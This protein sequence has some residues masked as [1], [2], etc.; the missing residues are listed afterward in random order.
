MI[1]EL[2]YK[3]DLQIFTLYLLIFYIV[4]VPVNC[5]RFNILVQLKFRKNKQDS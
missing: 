4:H 2:E 1:C 3:L 5:G